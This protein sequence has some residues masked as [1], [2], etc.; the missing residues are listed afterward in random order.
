MFKKVSSRIA[1]KDYIY[2]Y[3]TRKQ[4]TEHYV[5]VYKTIIW[6]LKHIIRTLQE[7]ESV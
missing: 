2:Q 1:F 4:D 3:E 5:C 6:K 7:T